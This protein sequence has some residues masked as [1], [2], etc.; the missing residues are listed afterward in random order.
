MRALRY[1]V[2]SGEAIFQVEAHGVTN[3]GEGFLE[4][5]PLGVAALK[6]RAVGE[7]AV[8]IAL[9]HHRERVCA[10][11]WPVSIIATRYAWYSA[12]VSR[13]RRIWPLADRAVI[14]SQ[15]SSPRSLLLANTR[16]YSPT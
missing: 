2:A 14:F 13:K 7:E 3:V 9:G 5:P 4:R 16:W 12:G 8:A 6:V 1:W 10:H 15:K 11:N